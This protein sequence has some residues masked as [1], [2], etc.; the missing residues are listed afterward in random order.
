MSESQKAAMAERLLPK[1]LRLVVR[2]ELGN[3]NHQK[4]G[5]RLGAARRRPAANG[6]DFHKTLN[7][8]EN[9]KI[10]HPPQSYTCMYML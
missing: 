1:N 10:S 4:T 2:Q 9:M 5:F 3:E 8:C 6:P 7:Y